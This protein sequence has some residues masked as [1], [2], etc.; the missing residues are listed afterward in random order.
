MRKSTTSFLPS[1]TSLTVLTALSL[2]PA[3][4]LADDYQAWANELDNQSSCVDQFN[5]EVALYANASYF[6][7]ALTIFTVVIA[8]ALTKRFLSHPKCAYRYYF[9]LATIKIA[10]GVSLLTALWPQCP[11][12]CS[13]S[14]LTCPALSSHFYAYPI[15]VLVIGTSWILRGIKFYKASKEEES[16]GAGGAGVPSV[17]VV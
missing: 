16:D 14:G 11:T 12:E 6:S 8:L 4:I 10:L 1:F 3:R 2:L 9:V 5:Q 15:I 13:E 17:E 7:V